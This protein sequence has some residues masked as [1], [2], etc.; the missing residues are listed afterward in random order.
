LNSASSGLSGQLVNF[1]NSG[2]T[3]IQ[4]NRDYFND[5]PKPGY[6]PLGLHPLTGGTNSPSPALYS[7]L[8]GVN[9]NTAG[10]TDSVA[11]SN[12]VTT[13]TNPVSPTT[14]TVTN[15]LVAW[16][17]LA[18]DVND[19]SG[20]GNNGTPVSAPGYASGPDGSTNAALSLNGSGQS[21]AIPSSPANVLNSNLT[22]TA[23]VRLN[24]M[25]YRNE[26]VTK[27][28]SGATTGLPAAFEFYQGND[29]NPG[30]IGLAVGD[31]SSA[32][33]DKLAGGSLS[34]N[35]WYF[36][37]ATLA[38]NVASLYTNGVLVTSGTLSATPVDGAGSV[39]I[40]NNNQS[41]YPLNGGIA[42][43]RLYNQALSPGDIASLYANNPAGNTG[44]ST[45]NPP[46]RPP[47]RL[48]P[49]SNLKIH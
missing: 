36:V 26:I 42:Q 35:I 5:T 13:A 12:V 20:Y 33:Y 37:A 16:Y 19:Y 15:G 8:N 22:I 43:V 24:S 2:F 45:P 18:G 14:Q 40:G 21:V 46:P 47:V 48:T 41:W 39:M 17:P 31:G 29:N 38:N 10:A 9:T 1:D 49:P 11:A 3:V 27:G 6:A 44:A 32:N 34:T 23:W 25:A 28:V 30:N 7:L 4:P